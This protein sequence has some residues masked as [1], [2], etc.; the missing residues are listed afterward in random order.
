MICKEEKQLCEIIIS[1]RKKWWDFMVREE[2]TLELRKTVPMKFIRS[3]RCEEKRDM[4]RRLRE[5]AFKKPLICLVYVPEEKAVCGCFSCTGIEEL[6]AESVED[7]SKVPYEKQEHYRQQG[8]G[9]LF[10]WKV[11]TIEEF[12]EKKPLSLYGLKR[13]PQSWQYFS[14]PMW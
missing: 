11:G 4:W 2:K 10:G 6:N 7:R 1:I 5:W 12:K 8:S 14:F 13:P 3:D 9:L